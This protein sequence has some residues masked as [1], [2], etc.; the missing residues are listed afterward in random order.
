MNLPDNFDPLSLDNQLCFALYVC[1]KEIIRRY[2][3][4]LDP[5]NLTYTEYI[6]LMSL[7]EKDDVTVKELGQR[8]FLD[9]GTLTPLLKKI[10]K[11]NLLTDAQIAQANATADKLKKE[12]VR[13]E[14][15]TA[16][17]APKAL[18]SQSWADDMAGKNGS[19]NQVGASITYQIV[20]G[21]KQIGGILLR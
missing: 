10:E 20:D 3:P 5:L 21:I 19:V 6:T 17:D 2:K 16:I 9:S 15:L 12:G 18:N 14:Q 13:V 8:L 7:W 4:L 11:Q 1:S